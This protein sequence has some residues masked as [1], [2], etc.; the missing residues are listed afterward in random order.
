MVHEREHDRVA[1]PVA[2]HKLERGGAT[3]G[4][5]G[6]PDLGRPRRAPAVPPWVQRQE[7]GVGQPSESLLQPLQRRDLRFFSAAILRSV[8]LKKTKRH[9]VRKN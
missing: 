5:P 9:R 6:V 8:N 3:R 1:E 4:P 7:R 2:V